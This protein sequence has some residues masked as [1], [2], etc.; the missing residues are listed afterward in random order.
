MFQ[1][2]L[3]ITLVHFSPHNFQQF[4]S[5]NHTAFRVNVTAHSALRGK[6][7]LSKIHKP[8]PLKCCSGPDH[9][10]WDS[11]WGS[12]NVTML[13]LTCVAYA[14]ITRTRPRCEYHRTPHPKRCFLCSASRG[15]ASS[16]FYSPLY[17]NFSSPAFPATLSRI[18]NIFGLRITRNIFMEQRV[19]KKGKSDQ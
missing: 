16:H 6:D 18:E 9:R 15:S 12:A 5:S 1:N 7:L 2:H 11:L 13:T 19:K 14:G 10:D 8:E 3:Q 17:T 4:L